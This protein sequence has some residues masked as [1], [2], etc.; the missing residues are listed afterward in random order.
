[1]G[2]MRN[3]IG[4]NRYAV[5]MY[6]S[7]QKSTSKANLVTTLPTGRNETLHMCID[8]ALV[9]IIRVIGVFS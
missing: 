8:F 4:T 1:M 6:Y 3:N 2:L 5:T 9:S 7:F